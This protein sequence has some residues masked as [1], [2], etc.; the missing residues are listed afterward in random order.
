MS[1]LQSNQISYDGVTTLPITAG[2]AAVT[3]EIP[4][5]RPTLA[6][7]VGALSFGAQQKEQATVKATIS[8]YA[9]Y[10]HTFGSDSHQDVSHLIN[11]NISRE[12]EP[13]LSESKSRGR[14]FA[15]DKTIGKTCG[16]VT[17]DLIEPVTLAIKSN[18]KRHGGIDKDIWNRLEHAAHLKKGITSSSFA[19]AV[20][21]LL[22]FLEMKEQK[23]KLSYNTLC[24]VLVTAAGMEARGLFV[25]KHLL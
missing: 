18:S 15:P 25:C 16:D 6:S 3:L 11:I 21:P 8:P 9:K 2:G 22:E 5:E 17:G 13:I 20:K 19:T 4:I 10:A 24:R 14:K 12:F 23:D 7:L 1:N